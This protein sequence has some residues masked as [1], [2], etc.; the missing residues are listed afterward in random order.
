M[1][2]NVGTNTIQRLVLVV[3]TILALQK[4]Q[5]WFGKEQGAHPSMITNAQNAGAHPSMITN[6][7]NAGMSLITIHV[8]K[9]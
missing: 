6:A 3:A 7:Q 4:S 9:I 2:N 8:K 5:T 1:L